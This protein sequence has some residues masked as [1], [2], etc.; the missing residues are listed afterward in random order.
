MIHS[1]LPAHIQG[2]TLSRISWWS[3]ILNCES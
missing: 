3:L 2:K 1:Y